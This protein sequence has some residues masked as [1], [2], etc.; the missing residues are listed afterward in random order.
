MLNLKL[1]A[2]K[3]SFLEQ[4][5]GQNLL[6]FVKFLCISYIQYSNY[7]Q[8]RIQTMTSYGHFFVF[9]TINRHVN[10]HHGLK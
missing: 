3:T 9:Y 8:I 2:L 6:F 5:K 10:M 4:L 7:S 1:I